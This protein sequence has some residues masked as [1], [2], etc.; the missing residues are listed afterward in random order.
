MRKATSAASRQRRPRA[1]S[2]R[3]WLIC[4]RATRSTLSGSARS[5]RSARGV[6]RSLNEKLTIDVGIPA[7][8]AHCASSRR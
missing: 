4:S 6:G 8:A 3:R 5:A 1:F 7:C 2:M